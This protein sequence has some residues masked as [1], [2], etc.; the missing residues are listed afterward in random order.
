MEPMRS[1]GDSVPAPIRNA[2]LL[3]AGRKNFGSA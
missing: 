3:G 2:D 1:V